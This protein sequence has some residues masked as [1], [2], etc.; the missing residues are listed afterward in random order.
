MTDSVKQL[1]FISSKSA[2]VLS[3]TLC[4]P[5]LFFYIAGVYDLEPF[6]PFR[7]LLTSDGFRPTILGRIVMLA[8][9][10]CL[11]VAFLIN[12]L[13]MVTKADSERATS[14]RLT[15]AHTIIGMS[16]L[17]VVLV[18]LS[19]GVLYELRP[20]VTPL[21]LGS[22]LGQLLFFL[23]LLALPVAFLLNRL[24][25]PP[26]AGSGGGLTFQPTSVNLIIGAAILLAILMIASAIILETT[27][28]SIGI[29][30]C[31]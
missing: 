18:A 24:P 2:A 29:P 4:L 23:G 11:P 26:K 6:I 21:G 1:S 25:R 19:D 7:H 20:F 27:A 22:T 8:V 9:L 31:D 10:L 30:N 16:I 5:F 28:C 15:P 12:L 3:L 17:L 13:P 14:F